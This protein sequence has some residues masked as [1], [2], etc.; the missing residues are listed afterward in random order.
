MADTTVTG[1]IGD[2][3]VQLINAAS[4]AT[5]QKLLEAFNKMNG[6][7]AGG[8][9]SSGSGS[10]GS[11]TVGGATNN[12]T[13]AM[14][15]AGTAV[16]KF[17]SAIADATVSVL[18]FAGNLLGGMA[19]G[20]LNLAEEL[21]TGGDK[22]S[23]FTK[24]LATLPSFLGTFGSVIHTLT[25]MLDGMFET[26]KNVREVGGTFGNSM[27][28]LT[29]VAAES[30]MTLTRFGSLVAS[31]AQTVALLGTS[32]TD[33]AKRFGQ[34]SKGLRESAVGQR[35]LEMGFTVDGLNETLLDYTNI[36]ARTGRLGLMSNRELTES[37]G[38]FAME[39]DRAAAASGVSRKELSKTVMD[40]S[41]DMSLQAAAEKLPVEAREKFLLDL[42]QLSKTFPDMSNMILMGV[43]GVYKDLGPINSQMGE[44]IAIT[45]KI[46][47]GQISAVDAQGQLIDAA[48][49]AR[50]R[51]KKTMSSA[52]IETLCQQ[53]PKFKAA[54]EA[55][56]KTAAITKKDLDRIAEDQKRRDAITGT[57]G[58]FGDLI[59]RFRA[60][61]AEAL[62]GSEAFKKALAVV[63]EMFAAGNGKLG[64]VLNSIVE[65][66][67]QF[68]VEVNTFIETVASKGW[69]VAFK[70]AFDSLL[71][72][73]F[74]TEN[75]MIDKN[76]K[77]LTAME[78]TQAKIREM[79]VSGFKAILGAA[80]EALVSAAKQF[81]EDHPFATVIMAGLAGL[82]VLDKLK[83][84]IPGGG[85]KTPGVGGATGGAMEGGGALAGLG[86]Q[87][88]QA[89]GWL[90]KGV[91]IGASMIAIGY[92]LEKMAEGLLGFQNLD[93]PTIGK[94]VTALGSFGLVAGIM[95]EF[96][97]PIGL[98]AAAI[99]GL[100]LAISM[101]PAG[102]LT[103]LAKLVDSAFAGIGRALDGVANVFIAPL[104]GL[105]DIVD[106]FGR[107]QTAGTEAATA[108]V[109]ALSN[110]PAANM[111]A[112]AAGVEAIKKALEGF[113]P[114]FLTGISEG[115]GS[116]FGKDK[117]G[118]LQQMAVLGPQLQNAAVGFT[119]F[120]TA[121][122]GMKL[123][124]LSMTSDQTSSFETLT[125]RLPDF[126][127]TMTA[128][129][130]QAAN[131]NAT[132]EAIGAFKQA[133]TGFNLKDFSFSKE[134]LVSL[135]DGTTKLRQLSEQLRA[136]KDGFQK[137]DQQG[138]K[139]IK[140]GVEG[141][142]KAFKDF[143]ESF[144]N[145]FIP[146]FE[147]L[148]S[149]TQEGLISDLG[150]KLDT[151]N[152]NVTNLITIE[153]ASK[154]NLDTIASKKPGK[155]Y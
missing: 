133:T 71:K 101:F 144:I 48:V 40:L 7:G 51:I 2:Q 38:Q 131:I 79:L 56:S 19:K 64:P 57:F 140:E 13:T 49:L 80:G 21:L 6:T 135:A 72:A 53:D 25:S 36:T 82:F 117:V 30:G 67:T 69:G 23:D 10:G 37:A 115:L 28:E 60:K 121:I 54:F 27:I 153:D 132:A 96:V 81:W 106:A 104:K 17:A 127:T 32:V 147:E 22:L 116:V 14:N 119:A 138:L 113:N 58:K 29:R 12:T 65:G 93:W 55:I 83:G 110:I 98:G 105:A 43:K 148:R 136:S 114:G 46:S 47:S 15:K 90:M 61:I 99:A 142:S 73:V 9:G 124:N 50:D 33:G 154:K 150:T 152:S 34:L 41:S 126:T 1:K 88:T 89:A 11:G 3:E 66:F 118:P 86:A 35:L 62:L 91:A 87:F 123:A 63:E 111:T 16:G 134:Q 76:G 108:S 5:L 8:G 70:N 95:G 52:Q 139:N 141:L 94:G 120:K 145:K 68:L 20:V 112:A 78:A 42:A 129:G 102:T 85:G 74:L 84:L 4:E 151:L 149:K 44:F 31:N 128:L 24:H 146:K 143:N 122:D 137:L 77:S 107:M 39:L 92:G 59:E 97:V 130:A 125:K 100:G 45:Q 75:D 26:Y 155:I 103:E 18:G 109:K